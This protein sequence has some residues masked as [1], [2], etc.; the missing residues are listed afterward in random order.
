M[1]IVK[2]IYESDYPYIIPSNL[3][4]GLLKDCWNYEK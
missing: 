4:R 2:V 1:I 3:E